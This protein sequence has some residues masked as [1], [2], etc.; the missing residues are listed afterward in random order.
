M[1]PAQGGS[2]NQAIGRSR[3]GPSSKVHIAVD[4][5]GNPLRPILTRGQVH[6]SVEAEHLIDGFS[7]AYLAADK[8]YDSDR[9]RGAR[10]RPRRC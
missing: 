10:C 8:A 6:D 1:P 9:F 3:G 4:G 7:G 5:L 2:Q